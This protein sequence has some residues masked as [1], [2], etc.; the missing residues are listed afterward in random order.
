MFSNHVFYAEMA[1]PRVKPSDN[2]AVSVWKSI[3]FELKLKSIVW[4]MHM[5][6]WIG[7]GAQRTRPELGC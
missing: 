6:L 4:F 7:I 1:E 2:Q 5:G 3:V